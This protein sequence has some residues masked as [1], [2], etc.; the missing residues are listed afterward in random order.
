MY[1]RWLIDIPVFFIKTRTYIISK[2]CLHFG[3]SS[4]NQLLTVTSMFSFGFYPV[5]TDHS[6]LF[7]RRTD[8]SCVHS[9]YELIRDELIVL[10][11]VELFFF[12][13]V[14]VKLHGKHYNAP[15]FTYKQ[16][17]RN[18]VQKAPTRPHVAKTCHKKKRATLE[19][20]PNDET[21]DWL[22]SPAW[23]PR[24]FI[25]ELFFHIK[26]PRQIYSSFS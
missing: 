22:L 10:V 15:S 16:H 2:N 18:L 8:Y 9:C 21:N 26:R 7:Y 24:T 17:I 13:S 19:S 20:P 4:A 1:E 25:S 11:W 12:D 6:F 23:S 14:W 5:C 3:L